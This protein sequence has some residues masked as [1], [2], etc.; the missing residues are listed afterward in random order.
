MS[1]I[2]FHRMGELTQLSI[3]DYIVALSTIVISLG[4]GIFF[5]WRKRHQN[6]VTNT[7][8]QLKM[9]PAAVSLSVSY[10]S[11]VSLLGTPAEFYFY[12]VNLCFIMISNTV[13]ALLGC[14]TFV[15]FFY[16]LQIST[17]NK[18]CA[19]RQTLNLQ[20]HSNII[21][22]YTHRPTWLNH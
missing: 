3:L 20:H 8:G 14:V 11:S 2:F 5:G 15:K 6:A 22:T 17:A 12:G 19:A 21:R 13:G 10:M 18:V 1:L 4:V 16:S 7:P 9:L